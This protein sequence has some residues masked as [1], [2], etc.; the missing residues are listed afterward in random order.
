MKRIQWLTLRYYTSKEYC[1]R[2][3]TIIAKRKLETLYCYSADFLGWKSIPREKM[4][5]YRFPA[6]AD[7]PILLRA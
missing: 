7:E 6:P 5:E 1:C 3:T 2:P 4:C